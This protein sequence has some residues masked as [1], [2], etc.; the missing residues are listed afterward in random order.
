MKNFIHKIATYKQKFA[1]LPVKSKLMFIILSVTIVCIFVT[2]IAFSTSGIINIKKQMRD[3]LAITGTIIS[4]RIN[5]ALV[6]NNNS[7]ALETLNA[8]SAN[9][10]I[11]LACVYDMKS[12]ISQNIMLVI[13]LTLAVPL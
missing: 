9:S 1:N 13:V 2:V 8:L 4:N 12:N 3:E 10:A 5:A 6:F 7:V 11:R